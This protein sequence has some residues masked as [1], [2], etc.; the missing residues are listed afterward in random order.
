[1]TRDEAVRLAR[2]WFSSGQPLADDAE[3][4]V[5]EFDLGYVIWVVVPAPPPGQ[6]PAQV[7]GVR[8]VVDGTTGEISSWPML[9]VT[10]VADQYRLTQAAKQRFPADVYAD[11]TAAGWFPGRDV[12]ASVRAW[13][14]RTGLERELPIFDAAWKALAEFG[15]LT[16]PQRGPG[17]RPGGG[18]PTTFY[19]ARY[20]PTT[21]EILDLSHELGIPLF[22]IAG[23]ED[24]P[25]HIVINERGR[26][27][28]LHDVGEFFIA[29]TFD[30]AVAWMVRGWDTPPID[31]Y[32]DRWR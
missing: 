6:I 7:G 4:G 23:H 3:L 18:F 1:M 27:F 25:S 14:D 9:P 29:D 5:H 17:G 22:P 12:S 19:P 15:Q 24:G 30:E 31:L 21:E 26:V 13:L 28:L 16:I 10:Y 20:A 11:I 2:A 8:V 32:D